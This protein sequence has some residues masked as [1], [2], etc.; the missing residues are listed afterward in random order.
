M[1][2]NVFTHFKHAIV[3]VCVNVLS[4]MFLICY[5]TKLHELNSSSITLKLSYYHININNLYI[6][7][8]GINFVLFYLFIPTFIYFECR[9]ELFKQ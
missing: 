5:I 4:Y 6:N 9:G 7:G 1:P 3:L 2:A 8:C